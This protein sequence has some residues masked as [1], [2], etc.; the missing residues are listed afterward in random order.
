M[1]G[2]GYSKDFG[3]QSFISI[4]EMQI[5]SGALQ[6]FLDHLKVVATAS[7]AEEG[8]L[9][10]EF[11]ID[12]EDDHHITIIDIFRDK[13]AYEYHL[14]KEYLEVF[15]GAVAEIVEGESTQRIVKILGREKNL[16]AVT[17]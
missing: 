2:S 5:T 11:F 8:L 1:A 7:A 6:T 9:R 10:C 16:I 15:R 14:T 13:E 3:G 17:S 4:V 12:Q